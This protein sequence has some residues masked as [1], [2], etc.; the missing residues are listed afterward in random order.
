MSIHLF[1]SDG[2]FYP[3]YIKCCIF[4]INVTM[5]ATYPSVCL[6]AILSGVVVELPQSPEDDLRS[7]RAVRGRR[8]T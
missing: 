2:R 8:K 4:A 6:L 7:A 3:K 5:T 1:F